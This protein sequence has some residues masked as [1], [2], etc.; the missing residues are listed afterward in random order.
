MDLNKAMVEFQC[1]GTKAAYN[2]G[3]ANSGAGHWSKEQR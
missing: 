3:I 2:I 1:G